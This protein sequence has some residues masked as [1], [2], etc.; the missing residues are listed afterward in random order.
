[1]YTKHRPCIFHLL[2]LFIQLGPTSKN[3]KK[4]T[5]Q[6]A[7]LLPAIDIYLNPRFKMKT[8]DFDQGRCL[9]H[10]KN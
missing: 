7:A 10:P 8:S 5:T 3:V 9:K 2:L 4:N 1:M 6:T